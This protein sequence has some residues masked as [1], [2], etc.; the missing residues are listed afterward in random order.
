MF[1]EKHINS[2]FLKNTLS[3]LMTEYNCMCK[4]L[5]IIVFNGFRNV[6]LYCVCRT[7]AS[8]VQSYIFKPSDWI[9]QLYTHLKS[10]NNLK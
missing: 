8:K 3:F 9:D 2:V 7:K 6:F 10:F 1:K 4:T 5:A